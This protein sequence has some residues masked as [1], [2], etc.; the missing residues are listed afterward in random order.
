MGKTRE[1]EPNSIQ[2]SGDAQ[3]TSESVENAYHSMVMDA[4]GLDFNPNEISDEPPNPKA[5]KFFDMLSAMNKELLPGC[6]KHSQESLVARMLN[7]KEEHHMS[8]REFDDIAPL[9]KEVVPNENLMTENFYNV[10]K[11]VKGLG[12]PVE[13][14]HCCNNGCM[15]FWGEDNDLTI[16]KICGHQRYKRPT[17]A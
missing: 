13:K 15:L 17:L 12:L 7:M 6:Q 11:M 10:K 5:Q 9:I 8:Q 16:C 1:M 4:A 3:P 14:I 2:N